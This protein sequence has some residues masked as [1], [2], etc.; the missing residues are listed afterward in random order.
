MKNIF[1]ISAFLFLSACLSVSAA[2]WKE[3]FNGKNLDGW[4]K[5]GGEATYKVVDGAIVGTTAPNTPN[6]FICPEGKYSDFELSFDVKCDTEL[7]SGV[8]IR[9]ITSAAE[10]PK[11]LTDAEKKKAHKVAE[12]NTIFGPQVEIAANGNGGGV[13]FEGV[14]GW[15]I[16]T[17]KKVAKKAYKA[18]EWNSYK[19]VAQGKHIKVWIND[20]LISDAEDK[21]THMTEGQLGFQVHGIGKKKGEWSVR[22]KNIKLKEL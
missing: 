9:S 21:R 15:V 12:R 5:R 18:G 6:T 19:I 8:Q 3:L 11:E 4:V 1:R 22:W 14:S 20:V 2:E 17:D 13:W 16:K 7:N 10:I